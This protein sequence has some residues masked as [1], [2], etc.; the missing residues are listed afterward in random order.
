[1]DKT[2]TNKT[3][4]QFKEYKKSTVSSSK[5][6]AKSNN[7][8]KKKNILQKIKDYFMQNDFTN[9]KPY[10]TAVIKRPIHT[11]LY[12]G[13]SPQDFYNAE[14]DENM[15]FASSFE[16]EYQYYRYVKAKQDIKSGNK[17]KTNNDDVIEM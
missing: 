1:M 15:F 8:E 6:N 13:H 2:S 3:V 4:E 10:M 17:N 12:F 14:I 9:D 11:E 5:N 16:A 7:L